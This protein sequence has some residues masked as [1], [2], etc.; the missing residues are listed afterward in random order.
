MKKP[1]LKLISI[2]LILIFILSAC[3][4]TA[5][6]TETPNVDTAKL[7]AEIKEKELK[8]MELETKIEEQENMI[9]GL[10]NNDDN[11][12]KTPEATGEKLSAIDAEELL[13]D[14]YDWN[15]VFYISAMDK[16]EDGA[17]LYG[18]ILDLFDTEGEFSENGYYYAWVN[19][20]TEMINFEEA[21]YSEVDGPNLYANI[22]DSMFPIPM[23]DGQV[24]PYD[25]FSP[26]DYVW[27]VAYSYEDKSVMESYQAQLEEAGFI[28]LGTVQSVDSLWQYEDSNNSAIYIVEMYNDG[29]TFTMNMYVNDF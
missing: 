15:N 17:V 18:F 10:E 22:P 3:G 4:T 6:V 19:S 14:W 8:I 1:A 25:W 21:G 7:E 27:G 5:P 16:Q 9:T 12:E 11:L 29:V 26:P 24:I 23:S 28:N 20:S 13:L 2:G